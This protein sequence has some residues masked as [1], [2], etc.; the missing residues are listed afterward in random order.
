LEDFFMKM[1]FVAAICAF[2]VFA[3]ATPAIEN[4]EEL[5]G[6]IAEILAPGD[7]A[8]PIDP[9]IR[10][11]RCPVPANLEPLT[12]GAIIV[13][14]PQLGWRIRVTVNST[15]AALTRSTPE[16]MQDLVQKGEAVEV[17]YEGTGFSISGTGI[18]LDA[19]ALGRP[20][21][22]KIPTS[23]VPLTMLVA[24]PGLVKVSR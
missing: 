1:L 11:G 20:V 17:V 22:V 13:R 24:G 5:D 16:A 3:S 9:R 6:R 18:A 12:N 4:V 21:R 2:P 15:N 14:C 23:A 19:A 7:A 8:V 10:L